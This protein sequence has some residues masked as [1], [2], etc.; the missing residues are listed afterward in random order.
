[1]RDLKAVL[2]VLVWPSNGLRAVCARPRSLVAL[3][4]LMGS[5]LGA[6]AATTARIDREAMERITASRLAAENKGQEVAEEEVEKKAT[7]ALNTR[8][9]FGTAAILIGVP[10]WMLVLALLFWLVGR[11]S[12]P[13]VRFRAGYALAA[14]ASIPLALRQL[15][16][17]PVILRYPGLHPAHARGLFHTDLAVLLPQA[18]GVP[19][20]FLVD[21]FWIWTA[22]LF[23]LAGR[24]AGWKRWQAVTGGVVTWVLV[25]F[26][27]RGL[28]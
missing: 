10:V 22:V 14:H 13:R 6:H 15:L 12:R 3:L 5:L 19:G 27:G 4:V 26:A 7:I 2:A 24:G 25:G 16:S 21:P 8:R 28:L 23:A 17:V 1:M 11:F 20:A 18:A 9:I